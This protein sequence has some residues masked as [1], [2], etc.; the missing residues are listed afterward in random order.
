MEEEKVV[1]TSVEECDCKCECKCDEE[2][3]CDGEC[4]CEC[5]CKCEAPKTTNPFAV[6]GFV[7]ALCSGLTLP[8]LI[9][10]I[11]GLV[12]SKSYTKSGK[13]FAIAG[14]VICVVTIVCVVVYCI[15]AT[16][17]FA[18]FLPQITEAIQG[19]VQQ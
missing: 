18:A 12:R 2:C 9:L 15:A 1:E 19:V 11:I 5:D 13:G 4:K 7:L 16:A 8:A 14:I 3:K 10:S 6:I 17:V